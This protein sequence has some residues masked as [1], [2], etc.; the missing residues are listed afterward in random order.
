V[1]FVTTL[2]HIALSF[3]CERLKCLSRCQSSD[4]MFKIDPQM[5]KLDSH[6]TENLWLVVGGIR[7]FVLQFLLMNTNRTQFQCT[8]FYFLF[9]TPMLVIL[10]AQRIQ[11]C[12][13]TWPKKSMLIT[14][15]KKKILRDRE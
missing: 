4:V 1:N 14:E 2:W 15:I 3:Y 7:E 12:K 9:F 6:I 11:K 10:Y 13:S 5:W 8:N